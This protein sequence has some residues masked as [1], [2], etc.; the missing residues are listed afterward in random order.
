LAVGIIRRVSAIALFGA[1][2]GFAQRPGAVTEDLVHQRRAQHGHRIGHGDSRTADHSDGAARL[3]HHQLGQT[4]LRQIECTRMACQHQRDGQSALGAHFGDV[5]HGH[6][7]KGSS[8]DAHSIQLPLVPVPDVHPEHAAFVHPSQGD[9]AESSRVGTVGTLPTGVRHRRFVVIR[10]PV[11]QQ[12][13]GN[14]LDD[15]IRQ[16]AES[17]DSGDQID[18]AMPGAV[19]RRGLVVDDLLHHQLQLFGAAHRQ[20]THRDLRH[21]IAV[22][23]TVRIVRSDLRFRA[24]VETLTRAATKWVGVE[25]RLAFRS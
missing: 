17:P 20:P 22:Q 13:A 21:P 1:A 6:D 15:R 11:G 2:E 14:Q 10:Y 8:R 9:I 3:P 7:G 16:R 24:P 5:R 4:V 19:I 25:R 23:V 18:L 12:S